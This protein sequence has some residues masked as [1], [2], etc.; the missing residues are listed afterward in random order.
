M[1]VEHRRAIERDDG[2]AV[3]TLDESF[4]DR[5]Q[6]TFATTDER[7][8]GGRHVDDSERPSPVGFMLHE[9][10]LTETCGASARSGENADD[11]AGGVAAR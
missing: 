6:Q 9:I 10:A 11:F 2:D 8:V 1:K 3:A 4:R 5:L 7:R